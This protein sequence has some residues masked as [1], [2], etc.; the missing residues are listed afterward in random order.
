MLS[1]Q[2]TVH[3]C[4][5]VL[6]WMCSCSLLKSSFTWKGETGRW[7]LYLPS[8]QKQAGMYFIAYFHSISVTLPWQNLHGH[9]HLLR[10]WS[11]TGTGS[12]R[13]WSWHRAHWSSRSIWTALLDIGL[14]FFWSC[15]EPGVRLDGLCGSLPIWDTLWFYELSNF[16]HANKFPEWVGRCWYAQNSRLRICRPKVVLLGNCIYT[17]STACSYPEFLQQCF[18]SHHLDL[19]VMLNSYGYEYFMNVSVHVLDWS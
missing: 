6:V 8:T 7:E 18:V 14:D 5:S 2:H 4:H 19:S 9:M 12:P 15:V 17:C 1:F 13:Q 11:G 3:A 10:G 16:K